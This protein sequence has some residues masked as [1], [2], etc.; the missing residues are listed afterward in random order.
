MKPSERHQQDVQAEKALDEDPIS[1]ISPLEQAA[2]DVALN[3]IL[4]M[5]M[6]QFAICRV[7]QAFF[8]TKK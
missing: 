4:G 3:V 2:K 8:N 1:F 5:R 6:K 7:R